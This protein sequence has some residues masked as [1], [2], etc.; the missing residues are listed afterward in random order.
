[1]GK[2]ENKTTEN[3]ASVDA[4]LNSVK[5]EKKRADSFAIK[6]MMER[7]TGK[8]AKMWGTAIVGFDVYHYKYDSGREGDFMKVGFSPR[9]QNLTLYIM[10]GFERYDS[11]MKKLGKYKTGKSCLY[12]KRLE[13]IDLEVLEQLIQESYDYMTKKYG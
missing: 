2:N 9:S 13:D 6:N 7:I 8:P 10:P 11:L 4:F 5:D 1:M 12:V 3:N